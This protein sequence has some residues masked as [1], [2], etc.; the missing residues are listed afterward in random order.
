MIRQVLSKIH[1]WL[2]IIIMSV[3][4]GE[5][6]LNDLDW[7]LRSLGAILGKLIV[8]ILACNSR[9]K[10]GWGCQYVGGKDFYRAVV[11]KSRAQLQLPSLKK[12]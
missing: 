9:G 11:A 4:N 3:K 7:G 2:A 5:I 1:P 12:I 8:N 6:N 10:R